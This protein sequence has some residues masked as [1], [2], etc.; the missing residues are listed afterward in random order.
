MNIK[1]NLNI[2]IK[3]SKSKFYG[4]MKREEK[5]YI[6]PRFWQ[7]IHLFF[8]FFLGNEKQETKYNYECAL[9]Q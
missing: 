2:N 8:F 6:F 4:G 1:I 3:I 7:P 9:N 5:I